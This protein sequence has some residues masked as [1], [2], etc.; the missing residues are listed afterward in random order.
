MVL[1]ER[2]MKVQG[3]GAHVEGRTLLF[4]HGVPNRSRRACEAHDD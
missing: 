3:K 1:G 2:R 4:F